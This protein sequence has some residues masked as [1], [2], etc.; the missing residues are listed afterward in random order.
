VEGILRSRAHP[1]QGFRSALG[2]MRLGK[3]YGA[4]R[5]EAACGRALAVGAVS[6]KSVQAILKH[7]LDRQPLPT[8]ELT[9][10]T[11]AHENLRG[12]DY[13]H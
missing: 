9:P 6:F 13:Y 2:L 7:G 10:T 4:E 8:P 3:D 12:P 11:P 5:L 1:Q